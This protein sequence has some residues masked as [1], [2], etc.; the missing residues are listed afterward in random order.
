ML[1]LAGRTVNSLCDDIPID[2]RCCPVMS[3]FFLMVSDLVVQFWHDSYGTFLVAIAFGFL[4]SGL[5]WW[6][7]SWI[8]F[9]YNRQFSFHWPHHF[10]CSVTAAVT[11]FCTV[12]FATCRYTGPVAERMVDQWKWA[13]THDEAWND[14]IFQKTYDAVFALRDAAGNQLEDFT[15]YPRPTTNG[16]NTVPTSDIKSQQVAATI[17]AN[18]AVEYFRSRYPF[19]SSILWP[20]SE[21]AIEA[22]AKDMQR[23]FNSGGHT[24]N[25]ADVL[26]LASK[27]ILHELK[28]KT[29][30]IVLL[31]RIALV[32]I[33]L[34]FQGI[35]I[36]LL[37]RAALRQI[38]VHKVTASYAGGRG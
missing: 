11:L 19:L 33:F 34:V 12:G 29:S 8:V 16:G 10:L 26:D 31:S 2:A 18:G 21:D 9:H 13:I 3:D 38:K 30:R 25:A 17:N 7:T 4:L 15:N 28:A 36:W 24:Y 37:I 27:T 22:V 14:A 6:F 20:H 35:T 32:V 1:K 23:V 5:S